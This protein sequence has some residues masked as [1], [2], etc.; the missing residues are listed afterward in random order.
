VADAR[1]FGSPKV[2]QFGD[3]TGGNRAGDGGRCAQ[4]EA[5]LTDALDGTLSAADQE[6]FDAHMA[7]CGPCAQ[8]LADAKRG[9]AWLEMLRTP[10]PE[11]PA[12]L[13]E[14]ILA[15]TSDDPSHSIPVAT[16][17]A[18][19]GSVPAMAPGYA[20][21]GAAYGNVIPFRRRLRASWFGQIL[22]QPR[23]A[24][25]AAMAFFS[26]TLTM[27][28]TGVHPL[29]LRA[30]DLAPGSLKRDLV[31]ANARVVRYYE[32][33]RVVYELESRVHDLQTATENDA[34][35]GSP[36]AEPVA[37]PPSNQPGSP[38]MQPDQTSPAKG[39]P[40][41]Q[42]QQQPAS[43]PSSKPA[44]K[45]APNSGTSRREG[46]GHPLNGLG[47]LRVANLERIHSSSNSRDLHGNNK[48]VEG[49]LA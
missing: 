16:L 46:L 12:T 35:A 28:L 1:K 43:G 14:R 13:L 41:D 7:E 17:A 25:T 29:E 3:K 18:H 32:G 22:L 42:K 27:N 30:S 47:G 4:C 26:I 45:P 37:A 48:N 23:L 34:T 20:L 39:S 11:P 40:A 5:M 19:P 49:S 24:M 31:S 33:L 8:M 15:Q 9:A 21:P 10:A 36:A 6:L 2:L 44:S 38:A